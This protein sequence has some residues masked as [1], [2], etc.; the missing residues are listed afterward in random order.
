MEEQSKR[1]KDKA[2]VLRT[3]PQLPPGSGTSRNLPQPSKSLRDGSTDGIPDSYLQRP[4]PDRPLPDLPVGVPHDSC[5][6]SRKT[7][8]ASIAPSLLSYVK[9]VSFLD[10]S[11]EYGHAQEVPVYK[12]Q[13][14]SSPA[15]N[16]PS[17]DS[18][19]LSMSDY[20]Y[21]MSS[22]ED[23][24]ANQPQPTL[25]GDH[26]VSSEN[27]SRHYTGFQDTSDGSARST[28]GETTAPHINKT[29]RAIEEKDIDFS[30]FPHL[31]LDEWEWI[32]RSPSPKVPPRRVLSPRLGR[33][34]DALRRN[35]S[36]SP[37]RQPLCE[38]PARNNS[39]PHLYGPDG[40]EKHGN[41]I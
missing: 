8:T 3:P 20:E 5:G 1:G 34:W 41:W 40:K 31:Q 10:E 13:S 7:S 22:E 23:L 28:N 25:P 26:L 16:P 37:L 19:R 29:A 18:C 24:R 17:P 4:L 35:R 14:N 33:L 36:R 11:V 15:R 2:F 12:T 30:K 32:R 6:P 38:A 21:C 9:D 27:M 39:T